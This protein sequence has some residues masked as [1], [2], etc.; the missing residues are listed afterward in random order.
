MK[1]SAIKKQVKNPE[2]VSIMVDN[3]Y[4]FSLS[5]DELLKYGLKNN[6]ELSEAELKRFKQLSADGKLRAKALEW[7]LVRPRSERE[8]KDY[9][10]KKK[11]EIN[12]AQKLSAEFIEKGYL[13]DFKFGLWYVELLGRRSKSR[14]AINAE[15]IKKGISREVR[16]R[17][18]GEVAV[19]EKAALRAVV[20][21][22][23]KLSRYKNDPQKL[24]R[25]LT[26]QGFDWA[27]VKEALKLD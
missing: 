11:A 20:E 25:Y 10:Y 13:D 16:E 19:D 23:Q 6:Q 15:L 27:E 3:K 12:L 17:V 2:R 18:L 1:V 22:K 9:M 21:K 4:G 7:L 14:R 5:L 8:F 24:A 26:S